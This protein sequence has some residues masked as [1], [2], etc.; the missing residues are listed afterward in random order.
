MSDP[1]S[2]ARNLASEYAS[3]D[4]ALGWFDR[5][6]TTAAGDASTIPWADLKPNP[7]FVDWA[8]THGLHGDGGRRKALVCGCGLGDDAEALSTIEFDVKAFDISPAAIEWAQKRFAASRVHYIVANVLSPPLDWRKKFD[9]ILEAYTLQVL[10]PEMQQVA[11]TSLAQLLAPGGSILLIA[12][13]RDD[14]D[15][16]GQDYRRPLSRAD[17]KTFVESGLR[18]DSFEDFVEDGDPPVRRFRIVYSRA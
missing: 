12:R 16:A 17:L 4:D 18:E 1:R 14:S 11:M 7:H 8:E 10:P 5:L 2:R 9:F 13:G 6:Y 3:T 15:P